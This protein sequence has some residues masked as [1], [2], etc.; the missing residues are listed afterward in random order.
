MREILERLLQSVDVPNPERAQLHWDEYRTGATSPDPAVKAAAD[1]AFATLLA[2]YGAAL[3]RHIWGF[4]RTD[5]AEDVFQD[6]LRKLHQKRLS[7]RLADF[8]ASVLPWLRTVAIRECVDAHRRAARRRARE[9]KAARPENEPRSENPNELQEVLAVALAR[10][11]PDEQQAIALHYFE[12]HDK[13]QAAAILGVNRD[14][15]STRLTSA[16]ARLQKYVPV[17]ASV[18]VGGSAAAPAALTAH[19]P[20]LTATRLGELLSGAW[21]KSTEAGWSIGR[22]AA[23]TMIGL[24]LCGMAAAAGWALTSESPQLKEVRTL[25]PPVN[26]PRESLKEQNLRILNRDIIP[27]A[28]AGLRE[29]ALPDNP[30]RVAERR[31]E[32]SQV[33]VTFRRTHPLKYDTRDAI[34]ISYCVLTR[35]IWV[36]HF[37]NWQKRWKSVDLSNPVIKHVA[38]PFFGKARAPTLRAETARVRQAFDLLP[39]DDRAEQEQVRHL[40]GEHGWSGRVFTIPSTAS[41][42]FGNSRTLFVWMIATGSTFSRRVEGGGWR[43]AGTVE[44]WPLGVDETHFYYGDANK[45][46]ARRIDDPQASWERVEAMPPLFPSDALLTTA[47]RDHLKWRAERE[48]LPTPRLLAVWGNRLLHIP[49]EPGPIQSRS[50]GN[51]E[52]PWEVMGHLHVPQE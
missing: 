34:R 46:F 12:G 30:W 48:A 44:A 15:L 52:S 38:V 2:W 37:D 42:V 41:Y 29:L 35:R 5:A 45:Y 19:P 22:A 1:A 47:D 31:A 10:L 8:H 3:Y 32:G 20:A 50:L 40:F 11:T 9:S 51:P 39:T 21:D 26:E 49:G 13:Q 36:T 17:P 7:T 28:L 27:I 24:T 43:Y 14:T 23:V 6:V 4:I 33:W 18:L 16:L 25:P